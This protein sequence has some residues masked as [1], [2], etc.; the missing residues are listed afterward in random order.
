[1]TLSH[2]P[3]ILRYADL[4]SLPGMRFTQCLSVIQSLPLATTARSRV[5]GAF[6]PIDPVGASNLPIW[7]SFFD[8]PDSQRAP[9]VRAGIPQQ[10]RSNENGKRLQ[11][12]AS[13]AKKRGCEV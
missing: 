3:G 6:V 13:R 2:T 9:Y 11:G 7:V 12:K 4:L 1:M 10:K 5:K 8:T